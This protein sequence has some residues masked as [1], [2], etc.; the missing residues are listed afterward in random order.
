MEEIKTLKVDDEIRTPGRYL[1]TGEGHEKLFLKTSD[2]Q[3][4][5]DCDMVGNGKQ[6]D[7]LTIEAENIEFIGDAFGKRTRME[8]TRFRIETYSKNCHIRGFDMVNSHRSSFAM[9]TYFHLDGHRPHDPNFK[10]ESGSIIDCYS[11]GSKA[12]TIYAGAQPKGDDPLYYFDDFRVER[13]LSINTAREGMQFANIRNLTIRDIHIENAGLDKVQ[14]QSN[15]LQISNCHGNIEGVTI[16]KTNDYG[17]ICFTYG[18]NF[19]NTDIKNTKNS[20]LFFGKHSSGS[21]KRFP[22]SPLNKGDICHHD[23]TVIDCP[24]VIECQTEEMNIYLINPRMKEGQK[25]FKD[26]SHTNNVH[27][28]D[29]VYL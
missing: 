12:E 5:F 3:A 24:E 14:H 19:K 27:I 10:W 6:P 11:I 15:G 1:L 13:V 22:N 28:I 16:D 29:P 9:K 21:H 25:I 18:V 17:I 20:A 8:N 4:Y 7:I 2:V 26:G 23:L